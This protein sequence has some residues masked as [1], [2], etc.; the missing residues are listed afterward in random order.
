M[1]LIDLIGDGDDDMAP[2]HTP[3]QHVGANASAQFKFSGSH[4]RLH[5]PSALHET[6][7]K[8]KHITLSESAITLLYINVHVLIPPKTHDHSKSLM[9]SLYLPNSEYVY[10]ANLDREPLSTC[11]YHPSQ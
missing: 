4:Y 9:R 8:K 6:P 2:S 7:E 3:A 11:P 10:R 1:G 5:D